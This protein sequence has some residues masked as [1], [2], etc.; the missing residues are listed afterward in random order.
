MTED[1]KRIFGRARLHTHTH[2]AVGI[3]VVAVVDMDAHSRV[4]DLLHMRAL[5]AGLLR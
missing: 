1:P 3:A 4:D 2:T 5:F